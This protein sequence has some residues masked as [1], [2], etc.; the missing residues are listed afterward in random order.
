MTVSSRAGQDRCGQMPPPVMLNQ[1]RSDEIGL[2]CGDPREDVRLL[3][4]LMETFDVVVDDLRRVGD[5]TDRWSHSDSEL[6][7]DR[8]IR[9]KHTLEDAVLGHQL[10]PGRGRPWGD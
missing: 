2:C 1:Q 7:A 5:H 6:V 4:A 9:E 10:L 3:E 8:S